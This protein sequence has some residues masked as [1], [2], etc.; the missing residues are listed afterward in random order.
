MEPLQQ[1][2]REHKAPKVVGA[3]VPLKA[4][5]GVL[6]RAAAYSCTVPAAWLGPL[7]QVLSSCPDKQLARAPLEDQVV[8]VRGAALDLHG[9]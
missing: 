3:D 9:T 8:N 5:L 4:L 7:A 6:E 2:L 1:A